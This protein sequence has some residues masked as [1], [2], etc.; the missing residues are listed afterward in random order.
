MRVL[1]RFGVSLASAFVIGSFAYA[2]GDA[3]QSNSWIAAADA[4][5]TARFAA[6][7]CNR[8]S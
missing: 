6:R 3:P 2:A 5:L 1:V 7:S 8:N 4:P